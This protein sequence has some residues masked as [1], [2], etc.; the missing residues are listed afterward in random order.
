M[1]PNAPEKEPPCWPEDLFAKPDPRLYEVD[2]FAAI[3]P[4]AVASRPKGLRETFRN[5]LLSH[6]AKDMVSHVN[7]L[8]LLQDQLEVLHNEKQQQ[9]APTWT[10]P[11]LGDSKVETPCDFVVS[12]LVTCEASLTAKNLSEF[13]MAGQPKRQISSLLSIL[14]KYNDTWFG[15]E[16]QSTPSFSFKEHVRET[17]VTMPLSA[18]EVPPSVAV[19]LLVSCFR[20]KRSTVG[21]ILSFAGRQA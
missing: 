17:K 2:F 21:M 20:T 14:P 10:I 12:R 18:F 1:T 4:M 11:S 9:P 3:K 8:N 15:D 13:V 6:P 7:E 5:S 16:I 19:S